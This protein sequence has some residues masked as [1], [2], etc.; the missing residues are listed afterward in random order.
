MSSLMGCRALLGLLPP[1]G[2]RHLPSPVEEFSPHRLGFVHICFSLLPHLRWEKAAT[3]PPLSSLTCLLPP[4][5]IPPPRPTKAPLSPAFKGLFQHWSTDTTSKIYHIHPKPTF[6][7]LD[8][9][10]PPP[11]HRPF[12][13]HQGGLA[14]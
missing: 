6:Q 4:S 5:F 7:V 3:A 10:P 9:S 2:W 11:S 14:P 13:S 8:F 12:L 1:P